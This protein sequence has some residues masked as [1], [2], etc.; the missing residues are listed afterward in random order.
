MPEDKNAKPELEDFE[1]E[2]V[3]ENRVHE[4]HAFTFK[5]QGEEF[6]GHFHEDEIHWLHPHPKQMIGGS[7]VDIIETTI[8]SLMRHYG[9]S[10]EIK[11]L[12][13][14]P[15]FEDR[16][17]E[18]R[19]FSLQ[20]QG[21]EFKGF[22]HEGEIQWFHPQPKQKLEEDLV[23]AIESEIHEKVAEHENNSKEND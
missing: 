13:L 17:H 23:E 14:K 7:K 19:Q 3:F 2:K 6:K 10:K 20:V 22:V 18:R 21:E 5:V 11:D 9:I 4:R 1:V 8:H 12:E 16:V 15:A